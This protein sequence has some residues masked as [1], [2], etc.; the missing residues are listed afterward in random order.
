MSEVPAKKAWRSLGTDLC[1][2]RALA[3][4][5][6]STRCK[7][8]EEAG[9]G[10]RTWAA[11][12][13]AARRH[14]LVVVVPPDELLKAGPAHALHEAALHLADVDGGVHASAHVHAD[15]RPQHLAMQHQRRSVPPRHRC[16]GD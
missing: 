5:E 10:G 16:Q 2:G 14:P 8:G 4:A 3:R 6:A 15:V 12:V 1:R 13:Q 9:N 7:V 11:R